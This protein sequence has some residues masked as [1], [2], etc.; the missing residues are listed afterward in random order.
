MSNARDWL[1]LSRGSNLPTVWSNCVAG[2][3]LGGAGAPAGLLLLLVS[4]TLL[5]TGGMFLNDVLDFEFD[6]THRPDRP[7]AAGRVSRRTALTAAVL[8]LVVGPL[9]FI[10][11]GLI[12]FLVAAGL[13]L[14]IVVYDWW[15]KQFLGAPVVMAGCR[16][17]LYL[18]AAS[19]GTLGI[20]G[21]AVLGAAFL[22]IYVVG[23]SAVAR[24]ESFDA[25]LP[26]WPIV[27]LT[28]PGIF[29]FI[30]HEK[31]IV[32]FALCAA[33]F[34]WLFLARGIATGRQVAMMLAGITLVDAMIVGPL[35]PQLLP[36]FAAFFGMALLFQRSIPAT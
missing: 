22:S 1:V 18:L 26:P 8:C 2:W 29:A 12:P 32:T 27:L 36:V 7:I 25:K 28:A 24:H 31:A 10:F 21:S 16:L 15:H 4:A 30:V 11:I 5:Y 3:W 35:A 19:T 6:R 33:F 17:L 13:A 20:S 14:C 34:A 23:I 9:P